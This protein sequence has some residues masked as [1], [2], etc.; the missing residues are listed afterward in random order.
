M[1]TLGTLVR[2][3]IAVFIAWKIK[4]EAGP[5]TA[6]GILLLYCIDLQHSLLIT[7]GSRN[8]MHIARSNKEFSENLRKSAKRA[9]NDE[10]GAKKSEKDPLYGSFQRE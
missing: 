4:G 3:G 1:R 2:Y 8:V 9:E 6:W 10:K 5:V 7:A